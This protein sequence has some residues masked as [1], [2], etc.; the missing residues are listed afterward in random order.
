MVRN[1][2]PVPDVDTLRYN[3]TDDN[4]DI[5]IFVSSRIDLDSNVVDN[6]MYI[7]IRCGA[8]FDDRENIDTLGD[9]TGD[10]ISHKKHSYCELTVQYWAWKN[11]KADYYGLCHYRRYLSFNNSHKQDIYGN[12]LSDGIDEYTKL[13]YGLEYDKMKK[14]ICENDIIVSKSV[15]V[16]NMPERYKNL[17]SHYSNAKYNGIKYLDIEDLH[18]AV[19]V[20]K[21][22]YPMYYDVAKEY[23][24]GNEG[25]FTN[26]FIMKRHIY[27]E[28]CEWLFDILNELE[29]RIDMTNY[30][31]QAYRTIGHISERLCGIFML[32]Q[33]KYSNN[34]IRELKP[35]LFIDTAK[36]DN[37]YAPLSN[38]NNIPIVL[39]ANEKFVPYLSVTIQ[40]IISNAIDYN[41][42]D[43]FILHTDISENSQII[44]KSMV[45]IYT[46]IS[47][48]IINVDYIIKKYSLTG[49][50]AINHITKETYFRFLI[51][52]VLKNYNKVIYLDCDLVVNEDIAKLYNEDV[53]GY[54]VAGVYDADMIGQL[55]I[56]N[57]KLMIYLSKVLNMKNPYLYLQAG[58]LVMNLKEFRKKHSISEWLGIAS[59]KKYNFADQD[60]LNKECHG[61]IRYIDMSWNTLIECYNQRYRIIIKNAPLNILLDYETARKD[62]KIIHYAGGQKPWNTRSVDFSEY[63]WR[64]ARNS[65]YYEEILCTLLS[66][67]INMDKIGLK[68][69][70]KIYLKKKFNKYFK[71]GTKCR[72]Y[73]KKIYYIFNRK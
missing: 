55:N 53:D 71:P 16:S 46:N 4:K 27:L 17:Y 54:M 47:I 36:N 32:Y 69:A 21:E 25:Y 51:Q 30:C 42:Y 6:P 12:I 45:D 18:T 35:I 48:R 57:G 58:V 34:K 64:Y 72:L 50:T 28:Y 33:R 67:S 38:N 63:F 40:S 37:D 62:P 1:S 19:E 8:I 11:V 70:S 9:D 49:P 65:P 44:L 39:A 7:P 29:N 43:I 13:I 41:N 31:E 15:N 24:N 73:M 14:I 5:K 20:L 2:K 60:I 61:K 3:G 23:L 66:S 68:G 52:D 10:N 26:M 56:D 22:K 59:A